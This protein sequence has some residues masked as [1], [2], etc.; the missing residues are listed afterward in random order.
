MGEEEK[1]V[2]EFRWPILDVL[3]GI[4]TWRIDRFPITKSFSRQTGFL[5]I[6]RIR[7]EN[8]IMSTGGMHTISAS[9]LQ[10]STH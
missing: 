4:V 7:I 8:K 5:V 6:N 1:T 10:I 3:V 2:R 9:Q